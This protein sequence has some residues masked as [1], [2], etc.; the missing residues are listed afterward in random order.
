MFFR[1]KPKTF[2]FQVSN[3]LELP[4]NDSELRM[5]IEANN[6]GHAM[7]IAAEFGMKYGL[8]LTAEF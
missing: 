7:N 8:L 1:N 5:T 4:Y 2:V 3:R 6:R